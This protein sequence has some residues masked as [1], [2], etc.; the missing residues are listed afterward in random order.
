MAIESVPG[1]ELK[2]YL[3]VFDKDGHEREDD[4]DGGTL[5]HRVLT[6][7]SRQPVSDVFL[8]SHGWKGDIPAARDQYTRWIGAMAA[9][10]ADLAMIRQMRPDFCPL[11]VGLHWPSLP[12]GDEDFGGIASF[13]GA[14]PPLLDNLI[15]SYVARISNTPPARKAIG[16][17]L[18]SAFR[19]D[20]P[21]TLPADIVAACETLNREAGLAES[22]EGAAPGEDREPFDAEQVYQ[23]AC[24]M[25]SESPVSFGGF[26]LS[27]LLA[28]LQQLSFWKMKE[29]ARRFGESGAHRFLT[30]IQLAAPNARVHLMGHSFGCIVMSAAVA[31]PPGTFAGL[32]RPVDTLFLVHFGTREKR[33][34]FARQD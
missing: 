22:G 23:D 28:P 24:L 25:V 34:G 5:S 31:G 7:L 26:Q 29:R 3:T 10:G 33:P 14:E 11:L 9:C 18:E 6:E 4:P 16:T 8:M 30:K 2:Y 17:I 13:D 1:T 21:E 27:G 19:G 20:T 12:F 15:E 32:P